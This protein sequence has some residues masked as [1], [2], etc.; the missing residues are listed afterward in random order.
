MAIIAGCNK[1]KQHTQ[2]LLL[3]MSP[4]MCIYVRVRVRVRVVVRI[5]MCSCSCACSCVFVCMCVCGECAVR[6]LTSAFLQWKGLVQINSNIL[7][8]CGHSYS[9]DF[10]QHLYDVKQVDTT[11]I[12]SQYNNTYSGK[13]FLC[14]TLHTRNEIYGTWYE[15]T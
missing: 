14:S 10:S 1:C 2:Q 5:R 11:C 6:C 3:V 8:N 12:C 9:E 7:A 13:I 4:C 15:R